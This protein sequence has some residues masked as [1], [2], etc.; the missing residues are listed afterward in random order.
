[1]DR[2]HMCAVAIAGL[3]VPATAGVA[4]ADDPPPSI[5]PAEVEELI[6]PGG[7]YEVEKTVQTAAIPP[8]IQVCLL[9]DETGS[10]SDDI[11]NLQAAAGAIFDDVDAATSMAEFAVAGFR[12][13]DVDGYG[14]PGD[15]VYRLLSPMSDLKADWTAGVGGLT[16]GGGGDGPEAQYDAIVATLNGGYGEDP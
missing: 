14:S 5:T 16:A 4:F 15:W 11:G 2:R 12:D 3:L 9:E 13:Y 6:L 8:K 1:M 7:S 10:F